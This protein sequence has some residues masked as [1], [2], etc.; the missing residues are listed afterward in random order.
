M[1]ELQYEVVNITNLNPAPYNPRK[2]LK[3][4][5][6]EYEKLKKSM[7]AFGYL[8]P[9][10]WNQRT[11]NVIGGHQRLK[12]L[13]EQEVTEVPCVVVDF[14][15]DTEKA[16]NLALNKISGDW[17]FAKLAEVLLD[18]DGVNFDMDLTGFEPGELKNIMAWAPDAYEPSAQKEPELKSECYVEIECTARALDDFANTLAEWG[19]RDGVT[20]NIQR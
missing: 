4:G 14:D 6:A 15:E 2:D 13:R 5:D 8:E 1:P 9:I 11:G 20:V 7:Q 18:L 3:P 10:V 12:V 19:K 16:A 17:D